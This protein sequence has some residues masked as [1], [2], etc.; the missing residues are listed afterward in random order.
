MRRNS[1]FP[2]ALSV[3]LLYFSMYI[4]MIVINLRG[5][6]REGQNG[7]LFVH[8]ALVA[9]LGVLLYF[10]VRKG[11]QRISFLS[12]VFALIGLFVFA[13]PFLPEEVFARFFMGNPP[14]L[15]LSMALFTPIGL[16]LFAN[17]V[18]S[19]KEGFAFAILLA[20]GE[21]LWS[22]IFPLLD[23]ISPQA[24]SQQAAYLFSVCC[25]LVGAAGLC[26]AYTLATSKD[27][28][29]AAP[30]LS[31]MNIR[32]RLVGLIFAAAVGN[33]IIISLHMGMFA[34]K[35]VVAS[36]PVKIAYFLML[37][38]LPLAGRFLDSHPDKVILAGISIFT[39]VFLLGLA[40]SNGF[41][42]QTSF[43]YPLTI[44]RTFLQVIMYV[45]ITKLLKTHSIL[46]LLIVLAYSLLPMQLIGLFLRKLGMGI[47]YGLTIIS[48][49]L[50]LVVGFCLWR[51]RHYLLLMPK[52]WQ[53]QPVQML[54]ETESQKISAF[55]AAYTLNAS[56][57]NILLC[58]LH[59]DSREDTAQNVGL[60]VRT[61]R[62]YIYSLL[63]KTGM[64]NERA[65]A[66]HYKSWTLS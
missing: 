44:L 1:F 35:M 5:S 37:F 52:L 42:A 66:D 23:L 19:G 10:L 21:L 62:H 60:A 22:L 2:P 16:F 63:R 6:L 57:Q 27:P 14:V 40:H 49:L 32:W 30:P 39:C 51:F 46:P 17:N 45:A 58:L 47:P 31:N 59:G 3:G 8:Y 9:I 41:I 18:P 64:P 53:A 24:L 20:S 15:V 38:L 13:V 54:D 65:L 29:V 56:E 34:P 28:E 50:A 43:F 7:G 4:G 33:L 26:V 61:V 12:T 48:L 36:S 25:W 11:I 55:A